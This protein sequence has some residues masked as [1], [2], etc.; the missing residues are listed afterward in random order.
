MG[1]FDIPVTVLETT[2]HAFA[3]EELPIL[4]KLLGSC[5]LLFELDILVTNIWEPFQAIKNASLLHERLTKVWLRHQ[6]TLT[7]QQQSTFR[8][9]GCRTKCLKPWVT[10]LTTDRESRSI[11]QI[12]IV[13]ITNAIMS[14]FALDIQPLNLRPVIVTKTY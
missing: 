13:D 1:V 11:H 10:A 9:C 14:S 4:N 5:H 2:R 7:H 8:S 6:S 12:D 3:N